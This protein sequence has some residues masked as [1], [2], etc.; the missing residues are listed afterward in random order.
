MLLTSQ[1]LKDQ[2]EQNYCMYIYVLYKCT[3]THTHTHTHD[4]YLTYHFHCI[5]NPICA[6]LVKIVS[7]LTD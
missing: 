1:G 5:L 2:I 3:H 4:L 7:P 6:L